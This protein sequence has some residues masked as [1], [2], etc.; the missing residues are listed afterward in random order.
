MRSNAVFQIAWF[1]HFPSMNVLSEISTEH[2]PNQR[3]ELTY[4][5]YFSS[6]GR[7][8]KEYLSPCLIQRGKIQK[9]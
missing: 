1:M 3:S 9:F 2:S 5:I 7:S 4:A 6:A 8:N